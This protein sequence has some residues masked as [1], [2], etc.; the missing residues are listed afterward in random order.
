MRLNVSPDLDTIVFEYIVQSKLHGRTKK[1]CCNAL[2]IVFDLMGIAWSLY[3]Y[4]GKAT[5]S[6]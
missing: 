2:L 5:E 4:L 3:M 6:K 1:G